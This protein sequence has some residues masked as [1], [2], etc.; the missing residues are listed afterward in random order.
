[1]PYDS[2][3]KMIAEAQRI[4]MTTH[5]KPD[6]DGMGALGA[7]AEHL[8]R[9]GKEVRIVLPT[10]AGRK[11]A[12]IAGSDKF[13]VLGRDV[14]PEELNGMWDLLLVLDTCT[15]EQL[16]GLR[17]LIERHE[18]R[19]LAIDHHITRDELKHAELVDEKAAA[20]GQIVMKLLETH[21]ATITP[22]MATSLYVSLVSDTGWFRFPNVTA[23]LMR[24][25]GR[26][27]ELGAEPSRIY[28]QLFQ[29]ESQAKIRLVREALS[30]L[31]VC[32]EGEVAY[33]WLSREMFDRS[34]ALPADTE[35]IIDEC[36]K[37]A[38][39]IV[40]LL[41]VEDTPG[42]IR[43][44]LRSKREVDVARIAAQFGGGGHE[45][46]AGCRLR[47]PLADARKVILAEVCR[48]LGRQPI[49]EG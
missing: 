41:F 6:G 5:V 31:T 45:R 42:T 13:E 20:T 25:G 15:W 24:M 7:L 37:V 36:Q 34:G 43:V 48:A 47:L 23:E 8:Q 26:L 44:S 21:Q 18:G 29:G 1:M 14:G 9:E 22:T 17:D 32:Q 2:A 46:A 40:G 28:E 11:Y 49:S 35:N 3:W 33:F 19:V 30:T 16:D 39:V 38:G 27:M 12:C 10:P 4:L